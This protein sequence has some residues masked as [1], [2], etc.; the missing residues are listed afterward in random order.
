MVRTRVIQD[1]V[2]II[3]SSLSKG[4]PTTTHNT[5]ATLRL[6]TNPT[7]QLPL[8]TLALYLRAVLLTI[9]HPQ[10]EPHL[11]VSLSQSATLLP[12]R[13]WGIPTNTTTPP[14]L[15]TTTLLPPITTTSLLTNTILLRLV[16]TTTRH[17][18]QLISTVTHLLADTT[19]CLHP[20]T[21]LVEDITILEGALIV[22]EVVLMMEVEVVLMMEVEVVLMME[23]EVVLMMVVMDRP[24]IRTDLKESP[25]LTIGSVLIVMFLTLTLEQPA[26]N[27]RR[28]KLKMPL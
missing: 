14:L 25:D 16:S 13:M 4:T 27:V 2:A 19:P 28:L 20:R 1:K 11:L 26:S 8:S 10:P 7:N 18:D 3:N 5:K 22:V 12:D 15:N 23:V 24:L 17:Q 6:K 9:T 21:L